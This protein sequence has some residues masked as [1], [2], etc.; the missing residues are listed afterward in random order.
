MSARVVVFDMDDTLYPE[1]EFVR[2]AL[3]AAGRHAEREWGWRGMSEEALRLHD[4][5]ARSTIFQQAAANLGR[6]PLDAERSAELLSVYRRHRPA[7]LEWF[8]DAKEAVLRLSAESP[9]EVVSD[10]YLPTQANKFDALG[11]RA[12]IPR[13][14]FTE[15]LGREHWKPSPAAFRLLMERHPGASFAYVADNPAKDFVAPRL[16]GWRSIQILR[17]GGVY[18]G[19]APAAG[20]EP[21]IVIPDM[22]LLERH[23][24]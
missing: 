11:A 18:A 22:S 8:P 2:S 20:G 4:A 9:L 3:A 17:P 6:D 19:V 16:L 7:A 10:G 15:S 21:D 12:W 5:G 14:V 1:R 24:S 23:L 13:P